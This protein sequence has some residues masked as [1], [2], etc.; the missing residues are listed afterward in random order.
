M[1]IVK[2]KLEE[3]EKTGKEE[4]G[5]NLLLI[6][7]GIGKHSKKDDPFWGQIFCFISKIEIIK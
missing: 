1:Y 6:I 5:H 3:I 2:N 4:K 7:T